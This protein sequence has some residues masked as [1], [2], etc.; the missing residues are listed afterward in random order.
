MTVVCALPGLAAEEDEVEDAAPEGAIEARLTFRVWTMDI[1]I[2]RHMR[3]NPP[4]GGC[5]KE[6]EGEEVSR[7]EVDVASCGYCS[8]ER[9]RP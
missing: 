6:D 4:W 5:G 8:S 1:S 3:Y 9:E 2:C 7:D